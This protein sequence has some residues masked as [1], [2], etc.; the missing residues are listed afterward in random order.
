MK[1]LRERAGDLRSEALELLR[2]AREIEQELPNG[3]DSQAT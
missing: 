2:T 1:Q 3:S